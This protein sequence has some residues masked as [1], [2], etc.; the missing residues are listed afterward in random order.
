MSSPYPLSHPTFQQSTT[1]NSLFNHLHT[2]N[3]ACDSS[4]CWVTKKN[5]NLGF[6]ALSIKILDEWISLDENYISILI[7]RGGIGGA[8]NTPQHPF[9]Y[10]RSH[11]LRGIGSAAN[12]LEITYVFLLSYPL[13]PGGIGG[14]TNI[15]GAF[16]GVSILIPG[17]IGGAVNTLGALLHIFPFISERVLAV[18]PIHWRPPTYF[19]YHTREGIGGAANTLGSSL[20]FPLAYPRGYWRAHTFNIWI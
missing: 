10:Y 3:A 5:L 17:G 4:Q 2:T 12:T 15:Q 9:L 8:A 18:Q 6:L 13:W 16:I 14:T 20:V 19:P 7:Y 1:P 11:T